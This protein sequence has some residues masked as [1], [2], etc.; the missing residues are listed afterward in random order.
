MMRRPRGF[1]LSAAIRAVSRIRSSVTPSLY[2]YQLH[3]ETGGAGSGG[4]GWSLA[5]PSA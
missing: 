2:G 3:H 5:T 1:S 4:A